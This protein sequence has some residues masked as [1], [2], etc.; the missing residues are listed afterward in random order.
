MHQGSSAPV[1]C[2]CSCIKVYL[3]QC[4]VLV[5]IFYSFQKFVEQPPT[6]EP[7]PSYSVT[8]EGTVKSQITNSSYEMEEEDDLDFRFDDGTA[9]QPYLSLGLTPL[10]QL[11]P[12]DLGM[13]PTGGDHGEGFVFPSMLPPI[14]PISSIFSIAGPSANHQGIPSDSPF[15][16]AGGKAMLMPEAN[17]SAPDRGSLN[18]NVMPRKPKKGKHD[19]Q[20]HGMTLEPVLE[21]SSSLDEHYPATIS[22]GIVPSSSSSSSND[23]PSVGLLFPSA[24]PHTDYSSPLQRKAGKRLKSG[25]RR[26][27]E[28]NQYLSV[29]QDNM[30]VK[31]EAFMADSAPVRLTPSYSPRQQG[32]KV[33]EETRELE[34]VRQKELLKRKKAEEEEARLLNRQRS[35]QKIAMDYG[36]TRK[37]GLD[38]NVSMPL[39]LVQQEA[40]RIEAQLELMKEQSKENHQVSYL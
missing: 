28:D 6:I 22:N 5:I 15:N 38:Q 31:N 10:S 29:D 8:Q 2:S 40:I 11:S 7:P 1:L 34:F 17:P 35:M 27:P 3:L 4:Y 19:I 9:T 26:K 12:P 37:Q 20:A 32:R 21:Q 18:A 30:V 33:R 25:T 24:D 16:I 36:S 39:N 23:D 13:S 14:T